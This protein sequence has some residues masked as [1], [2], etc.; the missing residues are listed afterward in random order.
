MMK[1]KKN[2]KKNMDAAAVKPKKD[3]KKQN[4]QP[5]TGKKLLLQICR[6]ILVS[7]LAF[8]AAVAV[9]VVTLRYRGKSQIKNDTVGNA[10][11]MQMDRHNTSELDPGIGPGGGTEK[12]S[13]DGSGQD[14]VSET[15]LKEGQILY[16]GKVYEFNED[17]LTFLFMGIDQRS[18]TVREQTE[19]YNG[20]C[21][22][23]IFLVVLNP[24]IKKM[25][26]IAVDRNTMADVDIY[27]YYGNYEET[28]QTQITIQHGYGD[29]TVK[30]AAYMEKAVSN[31]FYGL[32]INGYCA[33]N[34]SA[35]AK[36]ND[37]V[38]GVDVVCLDDLTKWD[39]S[40]VKGETIHLEGK[41]AYNYLRRRDVNEFASAERRL[42]RQRQYIG[43]FIAKAKERFKEDPALPA[44]MFGELTAYMTTDLNL[45]KTTYLATMAAGFDFKATDVRKAEG[46]TVMGE[47]YEEFYIDED[48]LYKMILDVFYEEVTSGDQ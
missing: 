27:D 29:G 24:H 6:V 25:Q 38:G 11:Q 35:I 9:F 2:E 15:D 33:V 16:E 26:I 7:V 14:A 18:E 8:L 20:G 28:I 17:I 23:A 43:A 39:K 10:A 37:A 40:L 36:I 21:A 42:E 48:A 12:G 13:V 19:G 4:R 47:R 30:S 46:K 32:P 3:G 22:D 34:M 1:D 44:R 31:L 5:K 41:H 45:E